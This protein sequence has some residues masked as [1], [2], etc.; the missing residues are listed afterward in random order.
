MKK[1][2]VWVVA[3]AAVMVPSALAAA[4]AQSPAGYCKANPG[5]IGSGKSYAS[6][7]AC[8]A[9][10]AA[11]QR[12]NTANAATACKAE[13]LLGADAFATKYGTNK[14]KNNALGK[15]VSKLASAKTSEQQTA[16]M[17]A[18]K[19]CRTTDL[20]NVTGAGKMYKNFGACVK[21]QAK[22]V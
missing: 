17:N 13:Q 7:G 2:I 5:L 15:C 6:Y 9:A 3:L 1:A 19:K 22:T 8:V 12:S 18:A 20:K 21:A 16:E 11:K 10:Q 14:S 4:P